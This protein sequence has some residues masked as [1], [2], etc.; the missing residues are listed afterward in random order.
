MQQA[1]NSSSNALCVSEP[2]TGMFPGEVLDLA[3]WRNDN[4]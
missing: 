4:H 1:L 3:W 2:L